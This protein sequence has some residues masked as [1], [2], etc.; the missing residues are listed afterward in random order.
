MWPPGANL[1][2]FFASS[3]APT[4]SYGGGGRYNNFNSY[5][6]R[7]GREWLGTIS[8]HTAPPPHPLVFYESGSEADQTENG[9]GMPQSGQKKGSD[10]V[11]LAE[12]EYLFGYRARPVH[13][14]RRF[15]PWGVR[16]CKNLEIEN[17]WFRS[18]QKWLCGR[19]LGGGGGGRRCPSP[20]KEGPGGVQLRLGGH[21]IL[22][23]KSRVVKNSVPPKRWSRP[24]TV[25]YVTNVSY[26]KKYPISIKFVCL[27]TKYFWGFCA[28]YS[29]EN[30]HFLFKF[31]ICT[32]NE[33]CLISA[34]MYVSVEGNLVFSVLLITLC[35]TFRGW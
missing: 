3:E 34:T 21:Q 6:K 30:F 4:Q 35:F 28:S 16:I 27:V 17:F 29:L 10:L 20:K 18:R 32:V 14:S 7:V 5:L 1:G 24:E 8:S 33:H 19:S 2:D 12:L 15:G 31:C 22:T 13:F 23:S 25:A 9:C 11:K 26:W